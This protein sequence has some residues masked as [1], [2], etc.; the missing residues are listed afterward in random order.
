MSQ[1]VWLDYSERERRK[2]LAVIN[3]LGEHE[4]R[5]E[6]GIGS[7]RDAIADALFPGTSTI[8]T[9]ARYYLLI[10]WTYQ[11]LEKKRISSAAIANEARR[12][13]VNLIDAIEKSDDNAGN[14]GKEARSKLKRLPSSIYWQGLGTWGIRRF[15]GSL[16][17]YHRSLDY[18]Y[19]QRTRQTARAS[20]RD[21]EHND[22]IAENW[23]GGLIKPPEGFPGECSLSLSRSEAEYLS[24]RLR[25]SPRCSESL[26]PL[27][28]KASRVDG[29]NFVWQHPVMASLPPKLSEIVRN[30]QN[31]SEMM[32]G[33]SLLYNLILAEQ[34]KND[35]LISSYR[36]DFVSWKDAIASR[37][38]VFRNWEKDGFWNLMDG[39]GSSIK[40]GTRKFVNDWW[41][42]VWKG[43][44]TALRDDAGV[45][46]LIREREK[47]LK[48]DL[49]RIG[50]PATKNS[51]NGYSG[52]GQMDYRW[53]ITRR[54]LGDICDGLEEG[55]A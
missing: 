47:S 38:K 21:L 50:N 42:F 36:E 29:V 30:A 4:T 10:P 22:L 49:A 45:R 15:S 32:H 5:D 34:V 27:L 2:M 41:S 40:T 12:A 16:A 46:Q 23:H 37:Q 43:E 33:A 53:W 55:D 6:L 31:F 8:M 18:Y 7:V 9:R 20:E 13:E 51:W 28:V 11:R 3:L 17:Q 52:S 1:F 35:E 39:L 54:L 26:L 24:E 19:G 44:L 48:K 14:I 25:L